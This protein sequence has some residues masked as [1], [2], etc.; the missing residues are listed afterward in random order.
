MTR[1]G[2]FGALVALCA[3]PGAWRWWAKK[4]A[5]QGP[6]VVRDT[7]GPMQERTSDAIDMDDSIHCVLVSCTYSPTQYAV[8][9][10]VE[11]K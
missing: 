9:R 4:P 5:P 11:D 7:I 1:R 8:A 2:F 3:V 6:F 10:Y